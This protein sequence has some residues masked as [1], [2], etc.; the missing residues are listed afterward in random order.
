MQLEPGNAIGIANYA[1]Q[2]GCMKLLKK[3][4]KFIE[5]NFSEVRVTYI[6]IIKFSI[7]YIDSQMYFCGIVKEISLIV[8]FIHPFLR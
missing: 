1:Q 8:C 3:C 4:S 2:H 5:K 6:C 7:K